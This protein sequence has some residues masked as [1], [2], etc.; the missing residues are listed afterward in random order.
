MGRTGSQ[1]FGASF[2][3]GRGGFQGRLVDKPKGEVINLKP[4]GSFS[5]TESSQFTQ[6]QRV[7]HLKFGYGEVSAVEGNKLTILFDKAGEKKVLDSFVEG[8]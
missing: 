2:A 3:E 6:G 1:A 5:T 8:V 7:F 4:K